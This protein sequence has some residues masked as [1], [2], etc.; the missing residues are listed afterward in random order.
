[1]K[2]MT[3]MNALTAA[4]A[5]DRGDL[6]NVNIFAE[7][8]SRTLGA[9][10]SA[11]QSRILSLQALI[12]RLEWEATRIAARPERRSRAATPKSYDEIC[13]E[14]IYLKRRLAGLNTECVTNPA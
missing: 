14:I 10:P 3:N 9:E 12:T 2:T 6:E 11:T 4:W 13:E 1:M 7:R 8:S 5:A